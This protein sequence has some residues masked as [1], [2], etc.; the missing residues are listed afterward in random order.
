MY[1]VINCL[2][3]LKYCIVVIL[4]R[5]IATLGIIVLIINVKCQHFS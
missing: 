5:A 2:E 3:S 1:V 4:I